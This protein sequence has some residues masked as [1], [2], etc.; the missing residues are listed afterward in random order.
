MFFLFF[1]FDN[2]K[3]VFHLRKIDEF[4]MKQFEFMKH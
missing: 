2:F 1:I 3:F 4:L